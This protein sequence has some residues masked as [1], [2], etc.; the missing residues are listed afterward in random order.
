MVT[1]LL[2]VEVVV[3]VFSAVRVAVSVTVVALATVTVFVCERLQ[4]W[5][6]D[7]LAVCEAKLRELEDV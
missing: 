4:V 7:V 2:T 3:R 5:C 1:T 6:D